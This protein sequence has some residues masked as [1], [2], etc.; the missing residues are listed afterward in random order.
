MNNVMANAFIKAQEYYD[1]K[2]YAHVL[3]VAEYVEANDLIEA[4]YKDNCIIVAIL[5][6]I[7]EDTKCTYEELDLPA[8]L[9]ASLKLLTKDKNETYIEYISK[10]RNAATT[11]PEA[12]WVKIAD[13]K[14]HLSQVETL[15]DKLKE[16]Y[17]AA[18][19]YLL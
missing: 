12:Y 9:Q 17:L 13:M 8:Y 7:I 3:R 15:S 6:D 11:R 1:D 16:K 10:I 5:H 2:T 18:L 14:D 4:E 19:P